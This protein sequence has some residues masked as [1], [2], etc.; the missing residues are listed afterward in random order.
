MKN[1]I[2]DCVTFFNENFQVN[3][4]FNILYKYVDKFVVCESKF[5]HKGNPKKLNFR[6]EQF[7]KFKDKIIYF[8]LENQFPDISDPWK[9]Q[10]YQREFMLKSLNEANPD[11]YIFFSDPDE[12]PNP[13]ILANFELKKKYGIFLQNCY[14]YKFN[15]YNPYESPWE[16]TRVAKKKNLKSID[17]M[18][19]KV[20]IRNL[21]YNFF[22]FDKEKSIQVFKEAGWHFNNIMSPYDIS[23]K[24]KTF[25]HTEFNKEEFS[26]PKIIESKILKKIDLFNRGHQYK[27]VNMDSSFPEFLLK[28]YNTYK[29]FIL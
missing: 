14:N 1:K 12:I 15:L 27:M 3:L 2:Y 28:N 8:V 7:D 4:R 18:R 29:D 10:A 23:K 17:F 21:R 24:L 11:D 25:A 13:D 22:R 26:S 6:I 19:Q 20:K 16:G 5:D 9:T